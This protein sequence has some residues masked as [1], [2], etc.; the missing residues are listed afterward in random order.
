[1]AC[2]SRAEWPKR[3]IDRLQSNR[4]SSP[5]PPSMPGKW[6]TDG[7]DSIR[8]TTPAM[9][10]GDRYAR[11]WGCDPATHPGQLWERHQRCEASHRGDGI[12]SSEGYRSGAG[13]DRPGTVLSDGAQD[14]TAAVVAGLR[15]DARLRTN[16]G[17]P[18]V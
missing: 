7:R 2:Q 16:A 17:L 12:G 14:D 1:M 3:P 9:A 11:L 10:G 4:L 18:G 6:S 5:C 13:H 8:S 15:Q